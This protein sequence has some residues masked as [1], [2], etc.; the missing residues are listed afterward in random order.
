MTGLCIF[1]QLW[2]LCK[3]LYVITG[4]FAMPHPRGADKGSK[5]TFF[6]TLGTCIHEYTHTHHGPLISTVYPVRHERSLMS[7]RHIILCQICPPCKC[8]NPTP[9][10]AGFY[11]A[12]YIP[13]Y[14]APLPVLHWWESVTRQQAL[15]SMSGATERVISKHIYFPD[16]PSVNR[17][18]SLHVAVS[19]QFLS[20]GKPWAAGPRKY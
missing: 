2:A 18:L 9:P 1:S 15:N 20:G 13:F 3:A 4:Y 5:D 11:Y 17:G 19:V 16:V 14:T 6:I 10:I 7:S 12:L 8:H